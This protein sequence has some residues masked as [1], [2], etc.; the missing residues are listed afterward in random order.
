MDLCWDSVRAT[1]QACTLSCCFDQL[2]AMLQSSESAHTQTPH[3]WF[4]TVP[5]PIRIGETSA[6]SIQRR[7]TACIEEAQSTHHIAPYACGS[8]STRV[9]TRLSDG[10]SESGLA[11]HGC[12]PFWF[13]LLGGSSVCVCVFVRVCVCVC[14]VGTVRKQLV[15]PHHIKGQ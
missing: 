14:D 12:R 5:N 3:I 6:E 1:C 10:I 15:T 8:T 7:R 9:N 4:R 11:L 2:G 13:S